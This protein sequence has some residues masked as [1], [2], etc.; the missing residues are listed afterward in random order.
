MSVELPTVSVELPTVSVELPGVSGG[1]KMRFELND[2]ASNLPCKRISVFD[3]SLLGDCLLT[4]E[5]Q[6]ISSIIDSKVIN[7]AM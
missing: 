7:Y 2:R 5:G 1:N 4:L 3:L 6:T